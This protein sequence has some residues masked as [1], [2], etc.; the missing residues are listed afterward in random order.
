MHRRAGSL[1]APGDGDRLHRRRQPDRQQEGDQAVLREPDRLAA[2]ERLPVDFFTEAS[3][4][5]AEDDE[6]MRAD[7]RGQHHQRL[8]RHREPQRRVAARD[9]E[10]SKRPPAAARIV[11]RVHAIQKAGIEVWCGMILGFDNDDATDLRGSEAV[12][13]RRR[14][15]HVD[16][17]HVARHSQDSAVRSARRGGPARPIR[18]TGIRHQRH[19]AAHDARGVARRLCAR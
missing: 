2:G 1:C 10:V 13:Q 18:R 17:R 19:S 16:D 8:H 3:L 11:E 7:G 15:S 4:D 6:L 5:L 14:V 12:P 9:Q